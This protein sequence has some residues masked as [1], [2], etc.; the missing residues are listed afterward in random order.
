MSKARIEDGLD[1]N[2]WR[3]LAV[4]GISQLMVVLDA[5]IVNIAIPNAQRDLGISA[6]NRQWIVTAYTL[7]FGS[8]LLL[9]GR[10]ADFIG[11][12]RA[13]MIGLAGFAGASAL[14]GIANSQGVLFGARAL[15]GVF[16]ALL[17][18]AALSLVNVTF[19]VPKERARAFG[20]YGAI[21]GG[22]AAIGLILG[23]TLTEYFSWR[24]CLGVNVPIALIALALAVPFIH[25]SKASGDHSYDIPGAIT[26]TIGLVSLVYGFSQAATHGW[27]KSS[28]Y[29]FFIIAAIFLS[30][31]FY[32]ESK[33]TGPILPMRV[34][35]ERNRGGSYLATLLVGAGLFTM[36][37]FLSIYLQRVLGY[38]PLKSGFAF[39]PFSLGVIAF[40]GVSS[41]L[42]PK[43]GPR[44]LML[45]GLFMGAIGLLLLSRITPTSTY[46]T[47]ILPSLIIMSTGLAMVFIPSATTG[48]HGIGGR[49]SGVASAMVNTSQQ[50]GGSLGA[51]LLN[52]VAVTAATSY[53]K[54]HS[55][56]GNAVAAFAQVHGFTVAFKFGSIF[57]ALAAIVILVTI[58]IGKDAVKSEDGA[59]VVH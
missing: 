25:E 27:S 44:P 32:I 53:T 54:A 39:L 3:A 24:W 6:A 58:N 17:A 33:T 52:T 40:A 10:I 29:Q 31:F 2:R 12:K 1:P 23:G 34:L 28:T 45:T 8:L 15:Q 22:G 41:T 50:I 35:A 19:T 38:S 37:L 51:A 4:I 30:V 46:A 55:E 20:V 7:A 57:L 36:F 26:V 56:M 18:P 42:M 59:V 14:G 13:F 47:H 21:A 11:R 49:D 48:L 16:G 9:G 5:S 43:V